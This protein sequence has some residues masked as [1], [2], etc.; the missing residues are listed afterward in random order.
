MTENKTAKGAYVAA[1]CDGERQ[2]TL[3]ASG[4][5]GNIAIA[6]QSILAEAGIKAAVV[7][8]PCLDLFFLQDA[9]YRSKILGSTPRIAVEAGVQQGWDRLLGNTDVFI[10]MTGFGASGPIDDLYNHFGITADSVV[11]AARHQIG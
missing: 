9:N 4:S 1:D 6:A 7:S 2:I 8:V 10:G 3:M 5:E 11:D